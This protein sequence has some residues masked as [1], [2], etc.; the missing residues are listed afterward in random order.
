[1]PQLSGLSQVA[2]GEKFD[3]IHSLLLV[4]AIPSGILDPPGFLI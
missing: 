4:E 3:Y 2:T 1:M